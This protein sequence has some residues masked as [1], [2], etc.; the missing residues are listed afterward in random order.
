MIGITTATTG[1]AVVPDVFL[2]QVAAALMDLQQWIE[3]HG[4]AGHEPYDLLNSPY[5]GQWLTGCP[6][7]AVGVI[8]IGKRFGGAWLRR[9]LRVPPS[10]NPKALALV[11]AAYC[12]LGQHCREKVLAI[13][14]ALR[15]LRSPGEPEFCWGYDWHFVSVRGSRLPKFGPNCIATYFCASALLD[16]ADKFGLEEAAEMAES[17]GRFIVTR[18]NRSLDTEQYLCISYTPQNRTLIY[19]NSALAAQLLARLG[20]RSGNS[21]YLSLAKR[22][23]NYLADQQSVDGAWAYGAGRMQGWRDGFHTS[24]NLVALRQYRETTGDCSFDDVISRGYR[25]YVDSFFR[26][27]GAPKYFHDSVYPID[28][29][30]CSQAMLTL[31]AF[32]ADDAQALARLH[33]VTAWTWANMRSPQGVFYYQKH[34]LWTDRTPYMRWGQAWMFRALARVQRTLS[35]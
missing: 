23:M 14:A 27:D 17:A 5:L 4:Y 22:A 26:A 28:I 13:I 19:N 7:A 1:I 3:R 32:R 18:L 33:Q 8:Q 20:V 31:C 15:Q 2:E 16:A 21:E 12:D 35:D 11:L 9:L 25:Y 6:P 24:Y 10:R 29:H 34:R 30:A